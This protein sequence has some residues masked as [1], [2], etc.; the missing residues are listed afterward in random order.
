[1]TLERTV[2][3]S[4]DG[5]FAEAPAA[6]AFLFIGLVDGKACFE[7]PLRQTWPLSTLKVG[8]S[9]KIEGIE[10]PDLHDWSHPIEMEEGI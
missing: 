1:M 2:F 4:R 3:F 5:V 8:C 10:N 9:L 7:K 6:V